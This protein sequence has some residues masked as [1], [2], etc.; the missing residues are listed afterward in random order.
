MDSRSRDDW[1]TSPIGSA[2][3][4]FFFTHAHKVGHSSQS[5]SI[6]AAHLCNNLWFDD[7]VQS[8]PIIQIKKYN[9]S[10]F[11]I[12]ISVNFKYENMK[13]VDILIDVTDGCALF[14]QAN[15]LIK[16]TE[17]FIFLRGWN[18]TVLAGLK[19]IQNSLH[20]LLCLLEL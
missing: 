1:L 20:Y 14:N 9:V 3:A 18:S 11:G 5:V 10:H 17:I 12:Y 15:M 19:T 13:K 8:Y 2:N 4:P 16:N 7:K 6:S